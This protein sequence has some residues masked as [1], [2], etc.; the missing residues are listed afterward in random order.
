M[1]RTGG[2]AH[3]VHRPLSGWVARLKPDDTPGAPGL[4]G[5][6]NDGDERAD[7]RTSARFLTPGW[8]RTAAE[9]Q[10]PTGDP[11]RALALRAPDDSL[12]VELDDRGAPVEVSATGAEL[13]ARFEER[14][15]APPA[16]TATVERLTGESL[17]LRYFLLHRLDLETATPAALFH[18]L[19]WHRVETAARATSA[20]LDEISPPSATFPAPDG[21]LRHWFT[22][23]A[24]SLAGPLSVLESG[25]RTRR[26]GPWFGRET[27]ALLSG[28]LAA[29]PH[30]L[31]PST[32][33]A[34]AGL[35]LRIGADPVLHHSARLAA[36]RL[37]APEPRAGE[38]LALMARLD[39][40]FVLRAAGGEPDG[41][42][43]ISL[44]QERVEAEVTVTRG[45][46][47]TVEMEIETG[48]PEASGSRAG[49]QRNAAEGPACYPVR[50]VPA[51]VASGEEGRA[52]GTGGTGAAAATGGTGAAGSVRYWMLL[53]RTGP[54]LHGRIAVPAPTGG[55]DVDLDG[56]PVPLLFLDRV[57]AAE[58][59]ASLRANE[60]IGPMRWHELVDVLPPRH[61][62]HAALATYEEE[63]P[64]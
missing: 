28:L 47:V 4:L 64:P 8:T 10:Q 38:H 46:R 59:L 6:I 58:L 40:T 18:C 42:M 26:P 34:L 30:R 63:L 2:D 53:D 22:P 51:G 13:V 55:F 32:R 27:S 14:W 35:A 62:A 33:A 7:A 37:S 49:H 50:L 5:P 9:V 45:G 3:S 19:P 43:S 41:P 11:V 36:A 20:L 15:T 21:P 23:A 52:G 60:L 57:P 29:D 1:P 16:D 48:G 39:S 24:T 56:P 17:E 54:V 25:L 12:V 61:P 31:P 44:G